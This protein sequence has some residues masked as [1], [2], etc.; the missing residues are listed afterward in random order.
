VIGVAAPYLR[1]RLQIDHL[2]VCLFFYLPLP[3][4][5][6]SRFDKNYKKADDGY[7]G[8]VFMKRRAFQR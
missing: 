4:A 2:L 6:K 8:L 7:N 1:K 3:K 5:C